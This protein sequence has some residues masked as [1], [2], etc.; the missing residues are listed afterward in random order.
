MTTPGFVSYTIEGGLRDIAPT[1]YRRPD[2]YAEDVDDFRPQF[3]RLWWLPAI[4]EDQA[5]GIPGHW[6]VDTVM[7][8]RGT[9][10]AADTLELFGEDEYPAATRHALKLQAEALAR[11]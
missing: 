11:G 3:V 8:T 9:V 2:L 7:V 1:P 4:A 6:A 10:I 5:E